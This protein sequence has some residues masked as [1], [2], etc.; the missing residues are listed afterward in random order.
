MENS[1]LNNLFVEYNKLELNGLICPCCKQKYTNPVVLPCSDSVCFG[2]LDKLKVEH[3]DKVDL[4]ECPECKEKHEKQP[5]EG[6]LLNKAIE[7]ILRLQP[8]K[9]TR[10]AHFESNLS[11]TKGT[12]EKLILT[13]EKS[14]A[15]LDESEPKI[16][17][18]CT[19]LRNKVDLSTELKIEKLNQHRRQFLNQINEYEK[20]CIENLSI[21]LKMSFDPHFALLTLTKKATQELDK[22]DFEESILES[23]HENIGKLKAD[24]EACTTNLEKKLFIE[25]ELVFNANNNVLDKDIIGVLIENNLNVSNTAK[26]GFSFTNQP[27]GNSFL[28]SNSSF[29]QHI[30]A[31]SLKSSSPLGSHQQ[32]TNNSQIYSVPTFTFGL[33]SSNQT[34]K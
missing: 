9:V 24:F 27:L 3:F 14:R 31:F 10:G 33:G 19:K 26:T 32:P 21:N 18:Y 4:L 7:K 20:K 13:A 2:C 17:D 30:N 29:Q 5:N 23:T 1:S 28:A 11:A 22:P 16:L 25:K 34:N 8:V 12:F 15:I 6:Y